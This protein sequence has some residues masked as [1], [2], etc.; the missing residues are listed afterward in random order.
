MSETPTQPLT[1]AERARLRTL[2][3]WAVLAASGSEAEQT[4]FLV[5][6]NAVPAL[7]DEND[8]LRRLLREA[9]SLIPVESPEKGPRPQWLATIVNE[10]REV[11]G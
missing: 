9:S 6:A 2:R 7:L 1:A 11:L 3:S 5:A 4:Y 10:V 8:R